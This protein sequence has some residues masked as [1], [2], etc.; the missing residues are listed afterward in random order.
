[1]TDYG[2]DLDFADDLDSLGRNVEGFELLGQALWRRLRTPQGQLI[3]DPDYGLDI[4]GMLS[5]PIAQAEQLTLPSRIR[6][7]VLKDPRVESVAVTLTELGIGIWRI[8]L[9]VTPS[10]GPSFD[11]V[12]SVSAMQ[13]ELLEV[14]PT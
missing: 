7:E 12:G 11:L 10:D 14:T 13:A 3:D 2:T 4:A 5:Q 9:R 6:G 8:K 1:V